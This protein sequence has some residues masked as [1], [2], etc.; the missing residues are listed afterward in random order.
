MKQG[1]SKPKAQLDNPQEIITQIQND[2]NLSAM[3]LV[4]A[5]THALEQLQ[6]AQGDVIS[7]L[8]EKLDKARASF[9]DRPPPTG[10]MMLADRNAWIQEVKDSICILTQQRWTYEEIVEKLK[11]L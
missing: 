9:T 4:E 6:H 2:V 7:L 5:R 3:Q 11:Q 1:I 8:E 10:S